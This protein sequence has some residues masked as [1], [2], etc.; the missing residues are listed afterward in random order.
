MEKK[1]KYH[2][3]IGMPRAGTTLLSTELNKHKEILVLPES[4]HVL[5]MLKNRNYQNELEKYYQ[6][7]KRKIKNTPYV[8]ND[9]INIVIKESRLKSIQENSIAIGKCFSFFDNN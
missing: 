9:Q 2:F 7:V 6:K 3:I 8:L 4:K 1:E 5:K